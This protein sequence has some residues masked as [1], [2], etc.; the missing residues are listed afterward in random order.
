MAV[1]STDKYKALESEIDRCNRKLD[2]GQRSTADSVPVLNALVRVQAC[3]QTLNYRNPETFGQ[4]LAC[5]ERA[6]AELTKGK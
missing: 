5:E 2:E 3:R 4:V 1:E 6:L